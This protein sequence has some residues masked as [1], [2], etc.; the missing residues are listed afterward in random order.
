VAAFAALVYTFVVTYIIATVID[1]TIGLR[2]TEDEEYVGLD[3][4]QHGER[5]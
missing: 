5:A 2:V 4:C 1:R 3:I